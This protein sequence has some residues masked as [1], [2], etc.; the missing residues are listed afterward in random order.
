MAER[1]S[2][3]KT[4]V[5]AERIRYPWAKGEQYVPIIISSGAFPFTMT[6]CCSSF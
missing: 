5:A 6:G 2:A 1:V 4:A 3:K